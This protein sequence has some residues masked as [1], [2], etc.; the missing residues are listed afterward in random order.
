ML[1]GLKLE[2][3][4]FKNIFQIIRTEIHGVILSSNSPLAP[5]ILNASSAA[6]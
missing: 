6:V 4:V 3:D 5:A 2:Q 1:L